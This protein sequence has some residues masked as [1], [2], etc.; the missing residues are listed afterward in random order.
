MLMT[1]G[2]GRLTF[3]S[4]S[5]NLCT[6]LKTLESPEGAF[7]FRSSGSPDQHVHHGQHTGR[8][9]NRTFRGEGSMQSA[10]KTIVNRLLA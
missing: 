6:F 9:M 7:V 5:R 10:M 2:L 4:P 8:Y 1:S 3:L